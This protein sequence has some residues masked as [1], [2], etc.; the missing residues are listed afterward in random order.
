MSRGGSGEHLQGDSDVAQLFSS[1][2][3][4][5]LHHGGAISLADHCTEICVEFI[6]LRVEG[7]RCLLSATGAAVAEEKEPD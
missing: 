2:L 1:A 7:A 5:E 4:G 6:G 3:R